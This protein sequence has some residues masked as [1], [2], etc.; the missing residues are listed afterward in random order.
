MRL[1]IDGRT[2]EAAEGQTVL[3]A[4]LAH[5]IYIPH[6]CKHPDL[7]AAGGCRLCVVQVKG[8]D[9]V[10]PACETPAEDGMEVLTATEEALHIRRMSME[11]MLAS[12]PSE[13]TDCPKYG[14]CEL[15]SLYQ[16]LDASAGRWRTKG[17]PMPEDASNPLIRHLFVRCIRCGRCVRAC[18]ELRGVKVLD[19]RRDRQ[20][21]RIG[22]EGGVSLA[23]AGCRFCGACV[24]VCPT[25]AITDAAGLLDPA[26]PRI[27]ALVPC[28]S[29]C[30]GEIDIPAYLRSAARGDWAA[31]AAVI[32]ERTP[33]PAVLGSIC[34]HPC[35]DRCRR[36]AVNEPHSICRLK[37]TAA[38]A[39]G[40]QWKTRR[41]RDPATGR[42]AAVVGSG[43][44]GLT[45]AYYLAMKGHD[46]TVFEALPKPGGQLR[47][48]I[49]AYRLP[50]A[51]LDG[52]IAAILEGGVALRTGVRIER[53][54]ELLEQGFDAVLVAAGT[55]KG[56]V[57]PLKGR[58]LP[59]VLVNTAFLREAR[60]G[61][62]PAVGE[63]VVVLGGGNV[64]MDCARTALRC[65]AKQVTV[66]CLERRD[67]M[68]A[69]P[70]EIDEA[71]DEGV[72][73]C[74]GVTFLSIEGEERVSGVQVQEVAAFH[75]D[76][77]RRAVIT[78]REGTERLLPAD[79]VIFAVGQSPDGAA[80]MGLALCRGAYLQT[81]E[82]GGAS[83]P[84]VFAAGDVVT[85]TRS[86]IEA[87][88]AGRRCA[89]SMDR[90]LGGDGDLTEPLRAPSEPDPYLGRTEGFAGRK[91]LAAE[92]RPAQDRRWDFAP[93]ERMPGAGAGACEA[94][95]CLQCDLRLRLGRNKFWNEYPN[96]REGV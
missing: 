58:D 77:N 57:L 19:Y 31:A 80:D 46:V 56:T 8:R 36:G 10:V 39:G 18:N 43:P 21:V 91:R 81:G 73:L 75:F 94:A 85:G 66:A 44:A 49:P 17:R 71:L 33:F 30:P 26:L 63:R 42:R 27:K 14:N 15:Q 50:D 4:A 34:P 6:L 16:Y 90:W 12:H 70:E 60:L 24:E 52:E 82:D 29:A 96:G 1:T 67:E 23:E 92:R 53:P 64:A 2:I 79:T 72:G 48:G 95:R 32:R 35:E 86:V 51:L 61:P 83:V 38:E 87:A 93:V 41:R 9:G 7:E 59:G 74:G 47:V 69:S 68:T 37:R 54:A 62:I 88:A 76:E 11:L 45:A 89:Q 5:D 65:G 22:T 13:C 84:G 20:G 78:P 28:R 55:H 3:Q 40:E 25:G